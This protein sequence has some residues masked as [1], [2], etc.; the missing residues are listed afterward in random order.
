MNKEE[1]KIMSY[2]SD[3]FGNGG[4]ILEMSKDINRKYGPAY[5]SNIYSTAKKLERK[6]IINIERQGNSR[7]IK[8]NIENPLSN[9]YISEVENYKNQKISTSKE[10]LSSIL[11]L[12]QEFDILSICSLGLE[13]YQKINRL[14]LLILTRNHD[15]NSNLI[16]SLLKV[17]SDYNI[18][19]DPIIFTI[20]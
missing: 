20:D 9:Y 7:L 18:K 4:S 12:T 17:E 13:K 16:K 6:G 14:E 2:L 3:N 5:Y 11:S 19:I 8:L 15:E 10:L 1:I